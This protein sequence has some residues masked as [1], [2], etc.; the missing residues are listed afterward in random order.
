MRNDV[1]AE[2]KLTREICRMLFNEALFT[3]AGRLV[4]FQC[5]KW[6]HT[7]RVSLGVKGEAEQCC[8]SGNAPAA[9]LWDGED[10]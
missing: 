1:F 3:V 7:W 4:S 5:G 2:G 9:L 8:V 10:A 6:G